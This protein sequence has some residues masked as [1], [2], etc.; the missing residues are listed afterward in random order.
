MWAAGGK[1]FATE[2]I[3]VMQY[4]NYI[5]DKSTTNINIKFIKMSKL[6]W[7]TYYEKMR[8]VIHIVRGQRTNYNIKS[9]DLMTTKLI[10]HHQTV[11]TEATQFT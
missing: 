6:K 3:R 5:S 7:Q 4:N 9:I 2:I 10:S 1:V 8:R 11:P